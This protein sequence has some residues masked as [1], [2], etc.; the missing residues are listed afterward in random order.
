AF[1]QAVVDVLVDRVRKA[2]RETGI[3]EVAIVGGV[4][5]N[6]ALKREAREAAEA[7]GFNLYI[8]PL[9]FST[10]NAA[11]IAMTARF[12]LRA[13]QTSPLDLAA[14]PNLAL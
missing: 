5:A 4:S 8:P 3:R 6:S 14:A 7:D 10:D 13:G 2:V 12:K 1:Q 9:A 11:M